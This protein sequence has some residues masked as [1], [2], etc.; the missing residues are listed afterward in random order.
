MGCVRGLCHP[1]PS[2]RGAAK[3]GSYCGCQDKA[4]EWDE[5]AK[6]LAL[7]VKMQDLIHGEAEFTPGE[8]SPAQEHCSC[9]VGLTHGFMGYQSTKVA[10]KRE[11][12]ASSALGKVE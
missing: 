3:E 8:D 9:Q 12:G 6:S 4:K 2:G 5:E 11:D 7:P 10:S 1:C